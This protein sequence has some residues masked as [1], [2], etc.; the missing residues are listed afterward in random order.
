MPSRPVPPPM[1]EEEEATASKSN[2][3]LTQ[4]DPKSL[5]KALKKSTVGSGGGS[6][7]PTSIDFS[8]PPTETLDKSLGRATAGGG[9]RYPSAARPSI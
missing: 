2:R 8:G 4:K 3:R 7:K 5:W 9:M 6:S 1:P